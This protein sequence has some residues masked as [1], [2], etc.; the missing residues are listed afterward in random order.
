MKTMKW[1]MGFILAIAGFISC[2]KEIYPLSE[3]F[4][5]CVISDTIQSYPGG[6]GVFV[7]YITTGNDFQGSTQITVDSDKG[8]NAEISKE[9][10]NEGDTVFEL[11]V[12]PDE[13][14]KLRNYTL[15]LK[16]INNGEYRQLDLVVSL[17]DNGTNTEDATLKLNAFK[18][19][20]IERNPQYGSA[21]ESD[22]FLYRTYQI[23]VVEHYTVLTPEYEIRFCYHVMIP[24]YDWSMIRIRKRNFIEPEFCARRETDGTIHEIPI[25]EYPILFGY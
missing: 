5:L 3:R 23:L 22:Y 2:N 1:L 17:V 13:K 15:Q 8:L 24:P 6:G 18:D 12:K 19:W 7:A 4:D 14:L 10:L 21:I 16:A 20:L 25:S 9:Q 11:V